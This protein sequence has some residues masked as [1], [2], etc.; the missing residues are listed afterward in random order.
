M[1]LETTL[2]IVYGSLILRG[3]GPLPPPTLNP[4]VP[5]MQFDVTSFRSYRFCG[6]QWRNFPKSMEVILKL[7]KTNTNTITFGKGSS[8][9]MF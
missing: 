6:G 3:N 7:G 9:K 5:S 1:Y 2:G 8:K 4:R